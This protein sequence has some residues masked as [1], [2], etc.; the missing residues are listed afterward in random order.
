MASEV[1][2]QIV[3]AEDFYLLFCG[4]FRNLLTLPLVCAAHFTSGLQPRGCTKQLIRVKA[5][6]P[7]AWTCRLRAGLPAPSK[8][9]R[10]PRRL[11]KASR[12]RPKERSSFRVSSTR[13][14]PRGKVVMLRS[15][16]CIKPSRARVHSKRRGREQWRTDASRDHRPQRAVTAPVRCARPWRASVRR[17]GSPARSA[18]LR[19]GAGIRHISFCDRLNR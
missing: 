14:Q 19:Y 10:S 5:G 8:I 17:S 2:R 3:S 13:G 4:F 12:S 1:N 9:M 11:F 6:R 15:F 7:F 18:K 16:V